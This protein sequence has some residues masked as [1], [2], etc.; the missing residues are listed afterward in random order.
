M[1]KR[2]K[3]KKHRAISKGSTRTE[4]KR[5]TGRGTLKTHKKRVYS[6]RRRNSKK[7]RFIKKRGWASRTHSLANQRDEVTEESR[8]SYEMGYQEGLN[9]GGEQLLLDHIPSDVIIP[10]L[11]AREAIAAGVE[12]LRN[13]GIPILD[14][15]AV[16][17]ELEGA[18]REKRAYAFIRL[19][20]GELLTLA[21]EKVLTYE[22]IK[23][24]G[25]FL[26]Y[27]G[28]TIPDL[29]AR[30][31]L[32]SCLRVATLIGVPMSRHPHFQPLLFAVLR[33]HGIDYHS[34][35]YT[36]STMNYS[37][38]EMG[39][40]NRLLIGRKILVIGDVAIQ[41]QQVLLEQGLE[42]TGIV[43][44]VNGYTD[45]QRVVA[46]ADNYDY[47]IALIAAGIAAIPIAVHL[48][49]IHGKV[50]FDFGHLANRMAGLEHPVTK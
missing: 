26:P 15:T 42:V 4:K 14:T 2:S 40:L 1:I 45:V 44:P 48:A 10:D 3:P 35:R 47:D 38:H 16:F 22:E 8:G 9:A 36:T 50:T 31:E 20:D 5:A 32:A 46:E 24:A 13:R 28:V 23:K 27:A 19:G 17:Q 7:K 18:L 25:A 6:G 11:T 21:Q 37:L 29:A 49:G 39:L 34:L 12:V 41:L 43:T 30:D 33:A